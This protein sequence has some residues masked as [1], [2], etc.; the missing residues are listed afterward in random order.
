[1]YICSYIFINYILLKLWNNLQYHRI[2]K[3]ITEY[4]PSPFGSSSTKFLTGGEDFGNVFELLNIVCV[5]EIKE[6]FITIINI[7]N[8]MCYN[9]EKASLIF[10]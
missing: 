4:L 3:I 8:C 2:N 9:M 1:M 5:Y 7:I 6:N 10:I